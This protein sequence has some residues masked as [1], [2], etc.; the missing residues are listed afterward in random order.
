MAGLHELVI[1]TVGS[2]SKLYFEMMDANALPSAQ[3]K[4]KL[5]FEARKNF[6]LV[7]LKLDIRTFLDKAAIKQNRNK[8]VSSAFDFD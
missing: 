6:Y 5:Y 4:Q 3:L 2:K 8:E 7:L 1:G